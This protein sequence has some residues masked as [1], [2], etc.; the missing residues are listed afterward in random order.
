MP[1]TM[2]P[3]YS[4]ISH[5]AN[6][7]LI[8]HIELIYPVY[9]RIQIVLHAI[10]NLSYLLNVRIYLFFFALYLRFGVIRK[11]SRDLCNLMVCF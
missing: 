10:F 6:G 4:M 8:S 3:L 2:I 7:K 5:N 1:Y 11:K 9:Y